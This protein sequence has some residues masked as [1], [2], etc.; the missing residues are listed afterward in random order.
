MPTPFESASLNLHLF[1]L[2]REP[3][4]REARTWFLRD[5]TPDSFEELVSLVSGDRNASFRMVLGYW[6][7]AASLVTTGAIDADA[8]RT[9]HGEL[10]ATFS[11]IHPFL[12]ELRAATGEPEF[13]K[14]LESVTLGAP[15]AAAI[16][17]RRRDAIRRAKGGTPPKMATLSRVAPE[18]PV[19]N[20]AE[21][22]Q[23][24]ET[25]LGFDVAMTMPEGDYAIVERDDVAVHL[26]Q[27]ASAA[28]APD[29]STSSPPGWTL[30]LRS[31]R[32]E[33]RGSLRR[34]RGSPGATETF[35]W[36]IPRAMSSNSLSRSTSGRRCCATR[37]TT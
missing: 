13:C 37:Y 18:L 3:V 2:R 27:S 31:S 4:L 35:A 12:A 25:V 10:F 19:H 11:K 24:Y 33:V 21:A 20:L 36:W 1:A 26:F 7:M 29:E 22:L 15:D 5:F 32:R 9:A 23:H 8:F 30:C 34:S 6:D 28:N 16:L 17:T 14:Q